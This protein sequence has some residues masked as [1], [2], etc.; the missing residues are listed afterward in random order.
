MTSKEKIE[1]AG[2]VVLEYQDVKRDLEALK[3]QA[4]SLANDLETIKDVLLGNRAG[5]RSTEKGA[6]FYVSKRNGRDETD[7]RLHY[8][9]AG[10][11][12]T[13][14]ADLNEKEARLKELQ[15]CKKGLGLD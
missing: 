6:V 5:S 10:K 14:I 15:E 1:L 3:I 8:P 7:I 2:K 11:I 9:D 12:E 13:T 4:R